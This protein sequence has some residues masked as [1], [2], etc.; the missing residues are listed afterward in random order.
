MQRAMHS[1]F[2]K[3]TLVLEMRLFCDKRAPAHTVLLE[4]DHKNRTQGTNFSWGLDKTTN[5]EDYCEIKI[6]VSEQVQH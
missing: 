3:H 5:S 6:I 2:R 1:V 4:S